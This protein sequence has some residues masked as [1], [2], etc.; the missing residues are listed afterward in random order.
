MGRTSVMPVGSGDGDGWWPAVSAEWPIGLAAAGAVLSLATPWWA[1][2]AVPAAF[3][4]GTRPGPARNAAFVLVAVVSAGVVAI[5]AVPAWTALGDGFVAVVAAAMTAWF[6][7]RFRRQY[8]ALV[9]AGWE[10]AAHLEREQRLVAEQARLRE[11]TRIAQDMHDVLGHELSLIALSA[12]ALKLAPGLA[13]EHRASAQDIRERAGTAVERLGEVVGLL[14]EEDG[15]AEPPGTDVTELVE[16]ASA[17]GLAVTL[18]VEGAADGLPP[19]AGRAAYRVVQEALTNAARH[20]P[21]APVSV[22]VRHT[23]AETRVEVEN[24]PPA[25]PAP[26][27]VSGGRGLIGLDERVRLAGGILAHGPA[28]GGFTVSARLPRDRAVRAD[29]P[30]DA[31]VPR[32]HRRARGNVRRTVAFALLLPLVTAALIGGGLR[33]WEAR[34]ARWSVL[35]PQDHAALHLGRPRSDLARLLPERQ[36]GRRPDVPEPAGQGTTC[37]YY[38]MTADLLD[39]RYGDAYR[40][41]FRAGLLVSSDT[42]VER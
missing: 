7:G 18:R 39:D 15:P 40:L 38:A 24:G 4:A 11:R 19:V 8:R 36:A 42:L 16:R 9:R 31:A 2:P 22:R 29:L 10:R 35:P 6:A 41:C 27:V 26:A 32:E 34:T 20:A 1:V 30:E 12:G 37:E 13:P 14:R 25:G 5:C 21:G 3:L 28:G 17:A 23:E 33:L